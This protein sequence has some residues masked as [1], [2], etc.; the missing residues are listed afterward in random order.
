VNRKKRFR[1]S[2]MN[3]KMHNNMASSSA[4]NFDI[5][6]PLGM[7][8][9]HIVVVPREDTKKKEY[10]CTMC[11]KIFNDKSNL[12]KHIRLHLGK[13][14]KECEICFKQFSDTS[15]LTKHSRIHTGEKPYNCVMCRKCFLDNSNL[16]KH[17]K[18]HV[19]EKSYKCPNYDCNKMFN[20]MSNAKKHTNICG[21]GYLHVCEC[22]QLFKTLLAL[23]KH[24]EAHSS[25]DCTKCDD[26]FISRNA[27]VSHLVVHGIENNLVVHG[28]ENNEERNISCEEY[29]GSNQALY[30][31]ISDAID[32]QMGVKPSV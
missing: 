26:T 32:D 19:N 5:L 28:I 31:A 27:L 29:V 11:S 30:N 7:E 3:E 8:N 13:K 15:N 1:K 20:D 2:D 12:N 14:P 23:Q 21:T 25:W 10:C 6:N 24:R 4:A 22:E 9:T 16:K 17:M 18:I